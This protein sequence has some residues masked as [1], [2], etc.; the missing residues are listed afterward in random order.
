MMAIEVVEFFLSFDALHMQCKNQIYVLNCLIQIS[1]VSRKKRNTY[2]CNFG[3]A[4]ISSLKNR[5]QFFDDT[6]VRQSTW[7]TNLAFDDKS[8]AFNFVLAFVYKHNFSYT[9][10]KWY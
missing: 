3:K 4:S 10:L 7:L 9:F 2:L 1:L 5:V 8:F 6:K